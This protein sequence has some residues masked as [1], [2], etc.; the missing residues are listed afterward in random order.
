MNYMLN[1]LMGLGPPCKHN[2]TFQVTLAQDKQGHE[3]SLVEG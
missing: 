1:V 2:V 3:S